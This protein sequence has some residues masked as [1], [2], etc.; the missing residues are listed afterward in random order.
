MVNSNTIPPGGWP[1]NWTAIIPKKF[2]HCYEGSELHIRLPS[3][4]P[5][6]RTGNSQGI[7]SLRPVG[8]DKKKKKRLPQDWGNQRLQ[9]WRIQNLEC[10]K[11]QRKGAVTPQETEPKTPASAA[12]TPEKAWV[13]KGSQQEWQGRTLPLSINPLGSSSLTLPQSPQ[14]PQGRVTSGQ[15]T[16]REGVQPHPSVDNWTEALVS[17]ALPQKQDPDLHTTSPSLSLVN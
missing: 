6:E 13:G 7:W 9:S 12:K 5:D 3:L 17:K 8:F 14:S 2:S 4:G 15:T 16:S 10:T 11:T 1:T